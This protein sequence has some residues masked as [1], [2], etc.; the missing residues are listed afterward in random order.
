MLRVRRIRS[1]GFAP[2]TRLRASSTRHKRGHARLA[3]RHK[4]GHARLATRHKRGH[5]RLATRYDG[6]PTTG[7]DRNP[8]TNRR[9]ADYVFRLRSSSCGG[10]VAHVGYMPPFGINQLSPHYR[11]GAPNLRPACPD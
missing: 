2:K 11:A 7:S 10:Q 1:S 8:P 6:G 4:R 3:T 9:M 5:A